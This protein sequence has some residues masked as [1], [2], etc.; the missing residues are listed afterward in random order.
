MA[1]KDDDGFI[2]VLNLY[3]SN[4]FVK[5]KLCDKH[6]NLEKLELFKKTISNDCTECEVIVPKHIPRLSEL[7]IRYSKEDG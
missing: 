1:N 5:V 3:Y 2:T 6:N 7:I 4:P